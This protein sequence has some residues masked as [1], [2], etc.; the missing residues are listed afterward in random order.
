M[1]RSALIIE[2]PPS[3]LIV[4]L[5]RRSRTDLGL[6]MTCFYECLNMVSFFLGKLRGSLSSC[7]SLGD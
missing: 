4:D 3:R 1:I 6:G 5:W 7:P 2:E